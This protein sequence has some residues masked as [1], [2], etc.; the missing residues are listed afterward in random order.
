MM[1][2]RKKANAGF[3]LLEL[4]V[5]IAV[6]AILSSLLLLAPGGFRRRETDKYTREL[7]NQLIQMQTISMSRTGEWRLALYMQDDSYYCVQEEKEEAEEEAVVNWTA[8][9]GRIFLGYEGAMLYKKENGN[10]TGGEEAAETGEIPL[11]VWSFD[12]DTGACMRGAGVYSV[13]GQGKT[14]KIKV[15]AQSGRCEEVSQ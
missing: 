13:T 7:R 5:V 11:F 14:K 8:R 2:E 12:R 15:Y 9:S 10:D 6:L 1:R 4:M 3:S